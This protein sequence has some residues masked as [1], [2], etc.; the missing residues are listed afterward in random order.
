[1]TAKCKLDFGR[2]QE[3]K[4]F[5]L[6]IHINF[7]ALFLIFWRHTANKI[8]Y[9][10]LLLLVYLYTISPFN[11]AVINSKL[12]NKISINK[13]LISL[14]YIF[15]ILKD[16]SYIAVIVLPSLIGFVRVFPL[17]ARYELC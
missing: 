14:K 15:C 7:N 5:F 2:G 8:Y 16:K 4:P 11:G 6:L 12:E 3:L 13:V 17:G 9:H 1:M 10:S